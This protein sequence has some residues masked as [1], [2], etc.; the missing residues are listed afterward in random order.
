MFLTA[1]FLIRDRGNYSKDSGS[2]VYMGACF[3]LSAK[4]G[5]AFTYRAPHLGALV[6]TLTT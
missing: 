4:D 1:P 5:F 2:F 6:L 3:V